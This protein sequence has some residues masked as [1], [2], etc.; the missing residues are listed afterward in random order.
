MIDR[1]DTDMRPSPLRDRL[2]KTP[3]FCAT[4]RWLVEPVSQVLILTGEKK[5]TRT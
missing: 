5:M 3:A 1:I 2:Q 4:F